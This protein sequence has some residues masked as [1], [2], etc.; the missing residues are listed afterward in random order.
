MSGESQHSLPL[1]VLADILGGGATSRLYRALV[2]EQGVAAGAGSYYRGFSIDR[3]RFWLSATPVAGGNVAAVEEATDKVIEK[4]LDE[5]ITAEELER[6]KTG[7]L[8]AA[9]YA[10]D[11]LSSAA[12]IFGGALAIGLNVE[13]IESWPQRVEAVTV[14]QV[15]EAARYVFNKD[16]SVTG[17]LLPKPAS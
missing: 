17:I 15:N 5:G 9:V 4:L 7:M 6:S 11:S 2:V 13:E 1:R 16:R 14:E 10:R 8:A 12:R 3:E